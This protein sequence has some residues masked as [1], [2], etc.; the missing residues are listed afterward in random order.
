VVAALALLQLA[1][2]FLPLALVALYVA[3][4]SNT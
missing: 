3:R 2:I 1:V 4:G